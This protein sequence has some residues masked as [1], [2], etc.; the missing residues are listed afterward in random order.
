MIFICKVK[1]KEV[2]GQTKMNILQIL[3]VIAL[4]WCVKGL[5]KEILDYH[6]YRCIKQTIQA[7]QRLTNIDDAKKKELIDGLNY[8]ISHIKDRGGYSE[9]ESRTYKERSLKTLAE[10]RALVNQDDANK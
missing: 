9:E 8:M 7:V 4:V 1:M 5:I 3:W 6:E 2:K 10:I